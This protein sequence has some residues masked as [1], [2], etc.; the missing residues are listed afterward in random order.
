MYDAV[1]LS[2]GGLDSTVCLHLLGEGGIHALPVFINYGQRNY[3]R[4][5]G[6][7]SAACNFHKFPKPVKFDF[8]SFG[9]VIK[10][11]LTDPTLRVNEDAFTPNRNLLFLVLGG[12]VAHSRGVRNIVL[13]FLT[14]RSAIFPDQ[15]DR[16]LESAQLALADS[17][18]SQIEI[19]CP[20]RDVTKQDVV[21]LAKA[22][23]ISDFYSCHSGTEVP[24]GKC[25]ACL[26]YA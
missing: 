26:E 3:E 16:F 6:A 17:L 18:G 9:S 15:T 1:C 19:H 23:G 21:K 14:E 20:L 7:L 24:C 11:G 22:R 25:I 12:A 8:P 4:E 5:W 13:G 10:S 2:S